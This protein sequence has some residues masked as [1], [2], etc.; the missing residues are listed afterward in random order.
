MRARDPAERVLMSHVDRH[1][2]RITDW[3]WRTRRDARWLGA[4][5]ADVAAIEQIAARLRERAGRLLEDAA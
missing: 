3:L 1:R 5:A 4:D 2:R